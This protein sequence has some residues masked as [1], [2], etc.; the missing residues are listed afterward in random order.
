MRTIAPRTEH[1]D[2]KMSVVAALNRHKKII[3]LRR[4]EKSAR[5]CGKGDLAQQCQKARKELG[6]HEPV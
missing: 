4:R 5:E 3:G 2:V 6:D 1:G